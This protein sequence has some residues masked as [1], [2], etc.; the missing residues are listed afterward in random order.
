M[1]DYHTI[2]PSGINI[3]GQPSYRPE[4]AARYLSLSNSRLAVFRVEG[5]GPEF[6][7]FCRKIFYTKV[8]LD[9][10]ISA[11]CR[12]QKA[13]SGYLRVPKTPSEPVSAVAA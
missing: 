4:E 13:T 2:T 5:E 8:D 3:D 7:Q 6:H 1:S 12:K 10:F 9:N 11:R